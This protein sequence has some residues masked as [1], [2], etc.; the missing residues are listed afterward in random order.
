M[1][2]HGHVMKEVKGEGRKGGREGG[3]ERRRGRNL[4]TELSFCPNSNIGVR[5]GPEIF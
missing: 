2:V 5:R 1:R 3:G 4:L